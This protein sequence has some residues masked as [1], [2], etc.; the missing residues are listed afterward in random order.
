MTFDD[1]PHASNT[2]RLL[3]MLKEWRIRATFF[4]VGKNVAEYPRIVQR[5][6]AEGHEVA[7]H[8]WSHPALAKLSDDGV[9][10]ELRKTHDAI[11]N[12]CGVAPLTYRPPYGA[13][14]L[15]QKV[16]IRQ[17]FG[18]PTILWDV[19]PND[20]KFRDAGVVSRTILRDSRA[21]SIILAHDIHKTTVDGMPSTLPVLQNKGFQFATVSQL[22]CAESGTPIA[23]AEAPPVEEA[24]LISYGPGTF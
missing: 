24:P 3:D 18:Y 12:A 5:I 20:W 6:V 1:G 9:R 10:A 16:W 22:I 15:R 23:Q 13:I 21:G 14:T 2:P 8:S 4:M 17:E 7:N 19:D 11:V